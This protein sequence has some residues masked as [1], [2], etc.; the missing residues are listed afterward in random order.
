MK[1]L[2]LTNILDD[3]RFRNMCS[4]FEACDEANNCIVCEYRELCLKV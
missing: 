1:N 4:V 3:E 2:E